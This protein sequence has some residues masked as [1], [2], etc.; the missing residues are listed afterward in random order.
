MILTGGETLT[1]CSETHKL[2]NSSWII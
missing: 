1:L 2:I